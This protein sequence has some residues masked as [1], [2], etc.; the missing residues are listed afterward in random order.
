MILVVANMHAHSLTS[1]CDLLQ[2]FNEVGDDSG[3]Q[4]LA[5]HTQWKDLATSL[6][7]M[8]TALT[9]KYDM[10]DEQIDRFSEICDGFTEDYR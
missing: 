8:Q 5:A 2:I 6:L 10:S 7:I 9:Y 3:I 4:D 1:S